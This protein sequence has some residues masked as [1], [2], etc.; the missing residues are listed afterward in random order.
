VALCDSTKWNRV[1][2]AYFWPIAK[3]ECVISE[4][5]IPRETKEALREQGARLLLAQ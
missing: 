4:G 2:V 1:S 3:V 5:Q